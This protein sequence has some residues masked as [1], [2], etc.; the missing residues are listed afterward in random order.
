[1]RVRAT[2]L[3]IAFAVGLGCAVILTFPAWSLGTVRSV[4]DAA[5]RGSAVAKLT[6]PELVEDTAVPHLLIETTKHTLTVTVPGKAP[7]VMKAQGA[8]ALAKGSFSVV[9]KEV[10]PLWQAPPTYFLRRGLQVPDEGTPARAMRGALG[11]QALFISK[12]VAIHSGP[13]WNDDVGGVK[14]SATDMAMLFDVVGIGA[15]VEVR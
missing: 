3:L 8:Y 2:H 5:V 1:M 11:S 13:I 9:R 6:A 10:E 12:A 15:A 4:Q 14:L 7:M